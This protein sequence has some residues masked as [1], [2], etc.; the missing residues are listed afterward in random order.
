MWNEKKNDHNHDKWIR[1]QEFDKL[2]SDNF[3]GKSKFSKGKWYWKFCKKDRIWWK[4][5]ISKKFK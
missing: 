2:I 3:T 4:K 5:K 1:T